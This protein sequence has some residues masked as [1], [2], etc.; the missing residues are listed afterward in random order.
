MNIKDKN[1]RELLFGTQHDD[2]RKASGRSGFV[3]Y[4]GILGEPRLQIDYRITD[5]LIVELYKKILEL[6]NKIYL[7]KSN[8]K[9]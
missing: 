1:L 6:E 5:G 7:C 2:F 3:N 4:P 8:K 9:N